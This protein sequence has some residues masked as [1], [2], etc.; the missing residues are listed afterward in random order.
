MSLTNQALEGHQGI[1]ID[2]EISLLLKSIQERYGYDF[3][4]YKQAILKRRIVKFL[5][6]SKK[7]SVSELISPLIHDP[8]YFQSF[9]D[10]ISINVTE[11]FRDPGV[12][13]LLR[14][15]VIPY[16]KTFPLVNI[17]SAGCATGEEPYS[18]AIL[19]AESGLLK[20]TYIYATDISSKA[21]AQAKEGVYQE[22]E[23]LKSE[24]HYIESG[25]AGSLS[26]YYH[27]NYNSLIFNEEL[28][29]SISFFEHNLEQDQS[30]IEAQ[31]IMCSNVLI[32]FNSPFQER[33]F[34]LL[35]ES[36]TPGGYLA[37]G[38]KEKVPDSL[39]GSLYEKVSPKYPVYKKIVYGYSK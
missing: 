30:F 38:V 27:A 28:R 7:E 5:D 33:L 29:K 18:L 15:E 31:L 36:L 11:L 2:L 3:S 21:I 17:W 26:D 34:R 19:A 37:I 16:L 23:I 6:E 10:A 25:G 35:H 4:I 32:Y 8:P 14:D 13:Q 12:F 39:L 9:I 20:R 24:K 1:S 22:D